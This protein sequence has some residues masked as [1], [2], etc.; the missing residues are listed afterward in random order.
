MWWIPTAGNAVLCYWICATQL[1]G[2]SSKYKGQGHS[3]TT[4]ENMTH[5]TLLHIWVLSL[6]VQLLYCLG[7]LTAF[8]FLADKRKRCVCACVCVC[9]C[10]HTCAQL[11]SLT[12]CDPMD[13]SPPGSSVHGILQARMLEWAATSSSRGSSWLRDGTS[14]S[15]ICPTLAGRCFTTEPPGKPLGL[16]GPHVFSC[17]EGFWTLPSCLGHSFLWPTLLTSLFLATHSAAIRLLLTYHFPGDTSLHTCTGEAWAIHDHTAHCSLQHLS[18][19]QLCVCVWLCHCDLSSSWDGETCGCL[20]CSSLYVFSPGASTLL[21]PW[22]A[23]GESLQLNTSDTKL[24]FLP[25]R[26][27]RMIFQ[28]FLIILLSWMFGCTFG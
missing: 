10:V 9:V 17:H 15:C 20:S 27:W 11:L 14:M 1:N 7:L 5:F 16:L 22:Q 2:E 19:L 13:C 18:Q 12:L 3:P 4:V 23:R 25:A 24:S 6:F 26:E 21:V 8:L 28:L